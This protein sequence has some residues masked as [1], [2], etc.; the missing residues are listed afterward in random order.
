MS[1][2]P[3]PESYWVRD[4]WLLAGEYP[5]SPDLQ[6]AKRKVRAIFDAGIRSFV[7][8]TGECGLVPYE[9]IASDLGAH[10]RRMSVTDLE[11]PSIPAMTRVLGYIDAEILAGFPV[12]VHCLVGAGRTGTA[13]GCWLRR[14]GLSGAQALSRIESLRQGIPG[15][16]KRSPETETQRR[17]VLEWQE[18][19]PALKPEDS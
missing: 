9:Q 8:L 19:A 12:Y 17:F 15:A 3:I 2:R 1:E 14:Q 4:G 16:W 13:V 10:Y 5:G 7:D 18:P 6:E 11:V